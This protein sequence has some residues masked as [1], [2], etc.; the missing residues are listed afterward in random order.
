MLYLFRCNPDYGPRMLP[1][2]FDR[3]GEARY[4]RDDDADVETQVECGSRSDAD[5]DRE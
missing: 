4:E 5:R 3:C 2:R 1:R